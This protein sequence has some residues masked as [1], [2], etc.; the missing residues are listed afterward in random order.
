MKVTAFAEAL[1]LIAACTAA[2]A[3]PAAT[4]VG[5]EDHLGFGWHDE[6]VSQVVA[7]PAG[8]TGVAQARVI[9]PDKRP[10]SSQMTDVVRRH[11]GTIV[12]MKVWF[13]ADIPAA[14]RAEY[15]IEPGEP[16]AEAGKI[17]RVERGEGWIELATDAPQP[18]G[19]RLPG[20]G[21]SHDLPAA[22]TGDDAPI[23]SLLLPSG[24]RLGPARVEAPF[25]VMSRETTVLAEGPLFAAVRV[26][27]ELDRGY[28]TFTAKLRRGSSMIE[29]DEE[30]N[31]G[32]SGQSFRDVDRFLVLPLASEGF[33][34]TQVWFG[35]RPAGPGRADLAAAV[36]PADWQATGALPEGRWVISPIT[37]FTLPEQ[38][39]A[40]YYHLQ[41]WPSV[42]PQYGRFVRHVEPGGDAIAFAALNTPSWREP[43][44]IRFGTDA[45]GRPV[46]K[47]PIQKFAQGWETD[48]FGD[49]S[50]NY[51][52]VTLGVAPNTSRRSYGIMLT[53][54]ED[55]A[56]SQVASLRTAAT[57]LGAYPYA[58]VR[59]WVFDWSDPLAGAD[60]A[61]EP[62]AAGTEAVETMRARAELHLLAGHNDSYSMANHYHFSKKVYPGIAAVID[63]PAKITA[64]QRKAIHRYAAFEA[65]HQNSLSSFPYGMGFHLNNPNMTIM[66]VEARVKSSLLAAG[67]PMFRTWGDRSLGLLQAFFERFTMESGAPFENPH[68]TLGVTFANALAVNRVLMEA[69]IG[70]AFDDETV[71]RSMHFMIN[72]L[73]PPDL[74]FNGLRTI[75]PL[76]NGSYQ[77]VPPDFA[78][79]AVRYYADRSPAFAGQLQWFA[80]QTYPPEKRL[81][82]VKDVVPPL[83]SGWWKDY[84]V[85][86]RHG[87]GTEHETFMHLLAGKAFGH[88]E[89]ET[90]QMAY[91]IYAKGHPIHLHFGNGY[92]PIWN[93]PWLRNRVSFGMRMEAFE[94]DPIDVRDA[95]FLREAEYFRAERVTTALVPEGRREYPQLD[96][97][98][99]WSAEEGAAFDTTFTAEFEPIPPTSW[100][101][102]MAFVKD[103]DPAGP[104]YFVLRD[105]FGGNPTVPTDLNLWFLAKQMR[106]RGDVFHFEGQV[107]TDMDV[108]VHTPRQF[109]P[110]TATYGHQQEPYGRLTGF[111]PRWHPDGKLA[112]RQTLL[113]VGQ[114]AGKPYLVVLYPRLGDSDPPATFE[115]VGDGDTIVRVA[116]PR[117]TDTIILADSPVSH[118]GDGF[119][120]TSRAAVARRYGD[121]S[122]TVTNLDGP[123]TVAILDKTFTRRGGFTVRASGGTAEFVETA[124]GA[125]AR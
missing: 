6:L 25:R 81:S 105:G 16:P 85:I 121:G 28:W 10:V 13:F 97:K 72:W 29:I 48:G 34:P 77:S 67:H 31:T 70:D 55:E 119:A 69:G 57:R 66:A 120:V 90:D 61:K 52:G 75:L 84:G 83:G 38:A 76:G 26:R 24:D 41:G 40:T 15:T 96:D 125:E 114:P 20:G 94:R 22:I 95:A 118:E 65:Y 32:D 110:V 79:E 11:D 82:I 59:D 56:T 42:M 64:E 9:G 107:K 36:T 8:I 106:R 86:F 123:A 3:A 49:K 12:S 21:E 14:G 100:T 74:R 5:L 113:R 43:M 88:Y 2:L 91:T 27:Y 46:A 103:T 73:T 80:N 102:Q 93:R 23:Q 108:F 112:E 17:V 92:F 89:N 35:G 60:W 7:V 63:D 99:R 50:P 37:G 47:L 104:N 53:A 45:N 101:R 87:F 33:R 115:R 19:I 122:I 62:T 39:N 78:T 98:N 44:A 30:F 111:D 18:V 68:Y 1:V 71:H 117:S 4:T 54:A 109:E 58:E 116:T 124:A 51:T